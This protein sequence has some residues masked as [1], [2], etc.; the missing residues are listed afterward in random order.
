MCYSVM[1]Q[2]DLKKLEK[3]FDAHLVKE[4]FADYDRRH[5]V[6]PRK[7]KP[8]ADH[9]RIYPGYHAPIIL[10]EGTQRVIKPMRYRLRPSWAEKEIPT[11]Y[12]TF[13]ARL[14]SLEIRD[15]WKPLFMKRH[16]L[17]VFER[18]FEWVEDQETGKKK[19]ISF[20]PEGRTEMWA[21]V[22]WDRWTDGD[23]YIESFAIITTDPPPE[24]SM[25]GHDRCPVFMREDMIETWLHPQKHTKK[26]IYEALNTLEPAY[27]NWMDAAA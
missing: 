19:V 4:S 26:K 22:L 11:K 12:N 9:P 16:G 6:N 14:D 17:I 8:L 24:V 1:V 15:S 23:D 25:M 3:R 20:Q 2:Q 5:Q 27:F 18:F 7:F 10:L 13:N 21:P